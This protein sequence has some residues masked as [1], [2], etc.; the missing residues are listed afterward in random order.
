MCRQRVPSFDRRTVKVCL[1]AI[2]LGVL[3]AFVAKVLI[4]LINFITNF[5]FFHRL[6]LEEASP[7]NNTLGIWAIGVPV[8]GGLFVGFMARYGSKAIRGHGIPEAMEQSSRMKA[9]SPPGSLS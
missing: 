4:L 1:V 2:V 6:S 3:A 7:G 9:A 8:I 5:A